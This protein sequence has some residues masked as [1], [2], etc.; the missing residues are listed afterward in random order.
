VNIKLIPLN[1]I[2]PNPHQVRTTIETSDI[3]ELIHS[4]R[5]VGIIQPLLVTQKGD[6]FILVAG[7]RRLEA[8]RKVELEEVPCMVHDLSD[9]DLIRYALIENIQRKDLGPLEEATAVKQVMSSQDLDIR[10]VAK[11]IGKSKSYVGERLALL[12]L[13]DDLK[14]AVSKGTL[15]IKKALALSK[16]KDAKTRAKLIDKAATVDLQHLK[17]LIE[18]TVDSLTDGPKPKEAWEVHQGL[19]QLSKSIEGFRL[20]KDRI[21]FRFDSDKSL[22]DMLIQITKLL[23]NNI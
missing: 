12:D 6:K 14:E 9:D 19:R 17:V 7:Q 3:E 21:S 11:L 8:S 5:D 22:L 10:K 18:K 16:L 23:Q 2:L 13:P 1:Q 4:V 20:Y 15:P